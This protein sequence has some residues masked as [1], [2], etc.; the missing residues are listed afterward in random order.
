M[1]PFPI[2]DFVHTFDEVFKS[3]QLLAFR[4]EIHSDACVQHVQVTLVGV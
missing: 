4:I 1:I 2:P 3:T